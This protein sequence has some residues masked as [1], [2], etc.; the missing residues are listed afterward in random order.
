M[1]SHA[2]FCLRSRD[3]LVIKSSQGH[4]DDDEDEDDEDDDRAGDGGDEPE[5]QDVDKG[6]RLARDDHEARAS[7]VFTLNCL[8]APTTLRSD[9]ARSAVPF[10]ARQPTCSQRT[11]A[12]TIEAESVQAAVGQTRLGRLLECE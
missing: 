8:E 2:R 5:E 1:I 12:L 7:V 9:T 4:E 3:Q 10:M 11:Y 6:E